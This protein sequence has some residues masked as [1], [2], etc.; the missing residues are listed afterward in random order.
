[1]FFPTTKRDWRERKAMAGR[2]QRM[3][4]ESNHAL[5]Q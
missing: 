4:F 1:M 5:E 3:R 2:D